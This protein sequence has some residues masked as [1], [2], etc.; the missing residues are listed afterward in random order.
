MR[1]GQ[2]LKQLVAER[3]LRLALRNL[4]WPELEKPLTDANPESGSDAYHTLRQ[5]TNR[6]T[7][8]ENAIRLRNIMR[9]NEDPSSAATETLTPPNRLVGQKGDRP[10]Q[11][12][13][14]NGQHLGCNRSAMIVP[15]S[16]IPWLF[17]H[18]IPPG[19]SK[20]V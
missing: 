17:G 1:G 5:P 19:G 2:P 15:S 7:I 6:L 8:D 20:T 16:R 10:L 12:S 4:D 14:Q 9:A 11:R 3:G 18:P 13:V